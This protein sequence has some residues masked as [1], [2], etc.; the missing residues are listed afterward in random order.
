MR[1]LL[2][3]CMII[4]VAWNAAAQAPANRTDAKGLKQGKWV[5]RYPGGTMRYEGSFLDDKPTGEWKRYHENGKLKA[6]LSYRPGSSRAFASLYDEDGKLYARG[7]FEDT[8]RDS[9]WNFYSGNQVVQTE[10]YRQG[11]K[12][13]TSMGYGQDGRLLWSSEWKNDL[14]D[15]VSAEYY[16]GGIRKNEIT[17]SS[18]SKNGMA[19]FYD[20]A[21]NKLME[22]SYTNDLSEG[23]WIVYGQGGTVKY[24]INYRKGEV[25][26][27]GALDSVQNRE[28]K[29]YDGLKG[30]IAEPKIPDRFLP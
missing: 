23:E 8:R 30:K 3:I 29:K 24:R 7:I 20:E 4:V 17:Y 5:G 12:E 25:I 1:A 28:F 16:P 27:G 6:V 13:G 21:G 2:T 19:R 22:G 15:G 11:R 14:P 26:N 18:G 9:T 10:N